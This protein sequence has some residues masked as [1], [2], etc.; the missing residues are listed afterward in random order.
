MLDLG[1]FGLGKFKGKTRSKKD[2][3]TI[4]EAVF[5]CIW[6][7]DHL[8]VPGPNPIVIAGDPHLTLSKL[9]VDRAALLN[10]DI[11]YQGAD[12]LILPSLQ[13]GQSLTAALSG[14]L[15][16]HRSLT[17]YLLAKPSGGNAGGHA[18]LPLTTVSKIFA[19]A[20]Q[21]GFADARIA[22]MPTLTEKNATLHLANGTWRYRTGESGTLQFTPLPKAIQGI[23][24]DWLKPHEPLL[25]FRH[26]PFTKPGFVWNDDAASAKKTEAANRRLLVRLS[27]AVALT[28]LAIWLGLG[29]LIRGLEDQLVQQSLHQKQAHQF[30]HQYQSRLDHLKTLQS[31]LQRHPAITAVN[32]QAIQFRTVLNACP[33]GVVLN[34]AIGERDHGHTRMWITGFCGGTQLPLEFIGTLKS[35]HPESSANL[36]ALRPAS[37]KETKPDP[38]LEKSQSW[39]TFAI[40]LDSP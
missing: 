10:I 9:Q 28:F 30:L 25:D 14:R 33:P 27:A 7:E 13:S 8:V 11:H 4:D 22:A 39:Y 6:A 18:L 29:W 36:V 1:Q 15:P 23:P 17:G 38:R 2:S 34:A 35:N 16:H 32:S 31:K 21:A 3:R 12:L 19:A 20:G 26:K 24:P 5:S 37:E 40:R